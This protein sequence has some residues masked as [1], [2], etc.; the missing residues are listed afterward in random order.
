MNRLN[1]FL[2]HFFGDCPLSATRCLA[3]PAPPRFRDMYVLNSYVKPIIHF[4]RNGCSE[5]PVTAEKV[6]QSR[7]HIRQ[8]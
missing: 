8:C 5:L 1:T 2:F 6:L 4:A 7:L 3:L